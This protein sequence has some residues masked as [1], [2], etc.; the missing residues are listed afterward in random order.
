MAS[1]QT[2]MLGI[3]TGNEAVTATGEECEGIKDCKVAAASTS[4]L[5]N[6]LL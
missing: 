5:K 4:L 3:Q 6:T 2:L 1:L